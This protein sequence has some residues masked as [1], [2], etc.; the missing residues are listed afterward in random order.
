MSKAYSLRDQLQQFGIVFRDDIKE[1]QIN[2][3]SKI[4]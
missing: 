4:F 1:I 2:I 3:M